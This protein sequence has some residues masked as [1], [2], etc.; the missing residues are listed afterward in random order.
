MGSVR[1]V[2]GMALLLAVLGLLYAL[3]SRRRARRGAARSPVAAGTALAALFFAMAVLPGE[4]A[5]PRGQ[6]PQAA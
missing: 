1:I 2:V 3:A 5:R 6:R 4:S